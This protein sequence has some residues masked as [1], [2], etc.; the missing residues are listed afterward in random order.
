MIPENVYVTKLG[1]DQ[2]SRKNL[3]EY[4][5]YIHNNYGYDL[6]ENNAPLNHPFLEQMKE[7][8]I[9]KCK[10][11]YGEFEV[12]EDSRPADLWLYMNNIEWYKGRNI[13]NHRLTSDIVGVYYL[14]IPLDTDRENTCLDFHDRKGRLIDKFYPEN[15]DLIIFSSDLNHSIPHNMSR[16]FRMALNMEISIRKNIKFINC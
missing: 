1:I 7:F 12:L 11:I 9:I 2:E 5:S 4:C 6:S 16:E 8:F 15:D 13:H 3:L 10:E 14:N